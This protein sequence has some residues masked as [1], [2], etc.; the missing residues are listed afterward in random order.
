M[1][2]TDF[3]V[4]GGESTP[5]HVARSGMFDLDIPPEKAFHL[6]TA[7]GER[8]WVPG[9]DPAILSGDG[10]EAGTV[11]VTS[12]GDETTIW[13]VTDFNASQR[14]ARYARVSPGSRAGTVEVG[15]RA[16]DSG[17]STVAVRYELTAL[18][19]SGSRNLAQ[20]DADAYSEMLKEWKELIR[21]A[22]IDYGVLV[23]Q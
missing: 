11:F 8:L 16:N 17:G 7:P 18:T 20:F 15:V 10:T 21:A 14:R 9:W 19:E 3:A 6:F 1:K 13:V 22:D 5:V 12:H 4:A 2:Q 23:P